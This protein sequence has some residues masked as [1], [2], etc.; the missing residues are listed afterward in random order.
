LRKLFTRRYLLKL[1]GKVYAGLLASGMIYNVT[2]T[3]TIKDSLPVTSEARFIWPQVPGDLSGVQCFRAW[4]R[5]RGAGDDP[6]ARVELHVAG[7]HRATVV[8]D[9][10]VK[11]T[12]GEYVEGTWDATALGVTGSSDVEMVIIARGARGGVVDTADW[13]NATTPHQWV[14]RRRPL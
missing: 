2:G 5:K 12:E 10:P 4:V 8:P 1:F 6:I 11:S 14:T 7:A 13:D 3:P 9:T